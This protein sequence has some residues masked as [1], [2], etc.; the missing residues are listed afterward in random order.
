M[1]KVL[2]E[3]E[4]I[5]VKPFISTDLKFVKWFLPIVLMSQKELNTR[6]I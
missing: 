5:D 3:V 2:Q 6:N 4:K 1:T